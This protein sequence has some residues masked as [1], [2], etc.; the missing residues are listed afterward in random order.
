MDKIEFTQED[1]QKASDFANNAINN[2]AIC[3][4]NPDDCYVLNLATKVKYLFNLSSNIIEAEKQ[5]YVNASD[6]FWTAYGYKDC[7]K[8]LHLHES[9]G[10]LLPEPT[11]IKDMSNDWCE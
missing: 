2:I 11:I 8:A 4:P 10:D 3:H 6:Y 9:H 7:V 5:N 1:L